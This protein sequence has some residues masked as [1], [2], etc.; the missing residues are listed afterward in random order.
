MPRAFVIVIDALGIGAM[1]D[2]ASYDDA[3]GA[4][5]LGN[6]DA[7]VASLKLP[8]LEAMGLGHLLPL[9]HVSAERPPLAQVARLAERSVGKDTTTG[10]WE[11]MDVILSEPFPTYPQG[12]PAHLIEAFC[13][14]TGLSGVLANKPASGTTILTEYGEQHELTGLPILYTSADSVWQLAA[15]VDVVPLETLY[16]WCHVARK[17]LC[18]EHEVSRVIARPFTGQ[19]G[20]YQRLGALRHDYAVPPPPDTTLTRLV[21]GGCHTLGMG[22]IAD[23]FCAQGLSHSVHT[24]SNAHGLA[25]LQQVAQGEFD[26]PAHALPTPS[27]SVAPTAKGQLV[28]I[29]LVET[30]MNY[31]HRR[32]VAGYA[33][34]LEQVDA[35]LAELLSHL[36]PQDVVMITGD[37]GCDPTAPGS[38]HTRE[39]VPWLVYQP[40]VAGGHLGTLQG[41]NHVGLK[42]EAHLLE[43]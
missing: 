32:D 39:Y 41:F 16:H 10:H 14:Q 1:P 7:N 6:I 34:A 43:A 25:L 29:N 36:T 33:H 3:Q 22:K 2:Y 5:T 35:G 4:N 21:Q 8:T 40:T 26:W 11:M 17:L 28:F 37:H 38:D 13:Q 12:F 27:H 24:N 18:G 15:H 30:D 31:G 20:A 23:I 42:A 9:R 19:A